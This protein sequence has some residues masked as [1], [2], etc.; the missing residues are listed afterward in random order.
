MKLISRMLAAGVVASA[1]AGTA[2]LTGAPAASAAG[3]D[4]TL[5]STV[6]TFEYP[7]ADKI[8]KELGIRLLRGDGHIVLAKCGSRPGLIEVNARDKDTFCFRVTGKSGYLSLNV[9]AVNGIKGNDYQVHVNMSTNDESKGYDIDKNRWTGVG[10]AKDPQGR[11]FS[12]LEIFA[13]K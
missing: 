1:V 6:E 2:V 9:P 12:L 3:T 13:T 5:P 7:Q 8:E 10:E 4:T 11:D